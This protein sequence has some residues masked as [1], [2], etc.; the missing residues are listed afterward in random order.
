[1]EFLSIHDLLINIKDMPRFWFY[2]PPDSKSWTLDTIGFCGVEDIDDNYEINLPKQV[3]EEGW[4][5]TLEQADIEDIVIVA[6]NNSD[7][8]TIDELFDS[9]VFYFENDA[10]LQY[11]D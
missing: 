3:I 4:I 9:F 8:P 7:N 11:S 6:N 10:F 5:A 2:L 1:M